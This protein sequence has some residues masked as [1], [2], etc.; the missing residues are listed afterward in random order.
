MTKMAAVLQFTV[1]GIP[2]LFAGDEIGASYQPYS[3]LTPMSWHDRFKLR[4]LY[5]RL[6]DLKHDMAALTSSRIQMLSTNA[7]SVL[8][9]VR[10]AVGGSKAVLVALN[11]GGK[12]RVRIASSPAVTDLLAQSGGAMRDLLTNDRLSLNGGPKFVSISMDKLSTL[13]LTP[14]TG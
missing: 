11:F 7:G 5:K 9:Y 3:N 10:P 13:V 4:P 12:G 8:A 2:A 14:E 1:P 6:I